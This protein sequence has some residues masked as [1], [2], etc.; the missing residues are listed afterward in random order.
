MG[1]KRVSLTFDALLQKLSHVS[2]DIQRLELELSL[3]EAKLTSIPGLE[4]V[5][6]ESVGV[7]AEAPAGSGVSAP[8]AG[9]SAS[10]AQE[11]EDDWDEEEDDRGSSAQPP[12]VPWRR[13]GSTRRRRRRRWNDN[14]R[15]SSLS[16]LL[17]DVKDWEFQG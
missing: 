15:G 2:R 17:Q 1:W 14:G 10:A 4:N 13:G 3:L 12:P 5:T 11:P 16:A 7:A 8:D 6:P 9:G